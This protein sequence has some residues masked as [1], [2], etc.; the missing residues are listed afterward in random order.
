[1]TKK[2]KRHRNRDISNIGFALDLMLSGHNRVIGNDFVLAHADPFNAEIGHLNPEALETYDQKFVDALINLKPKKNI[3]FIGNSKNLYQEYKEQRIQLSKHQSALYKYIITH[4]I[5]AAKELGNFDTY[6]SKIVIRNDAEM[7]VFYDYITL[8]RTLNHKRAIMQWHLDHPKLIN[9]L[10]K[11]IAVAYQ[12]ARFAILRL[13]KNLEYGGIK[14][15]DIVTKAEYIL[16]DKALNESRME[17][18]FFL[19]SVLDMGKYVMT[20]G[21]G[22]PL[23]PSSSTGKSALTLLKKH[24]TKLQSAKDIFNNDI[25]E[26]TREVFGF[27]L[28]AGVLEYM[29]ISHGWKTT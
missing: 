29:T 12:N 11:S 6:I 4:D 23:N 20:S 25:I 18:C 5:N 16:I 27:C 14:V 13:D 15:T 10:N 1:M 9:K 17:G 19:C 3:D 8:Y 26:C 24:L 22:I 28:R 2:I 7:N 21:G